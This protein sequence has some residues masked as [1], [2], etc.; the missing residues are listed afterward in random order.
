MLPLTPAAQAAV[1]R[2]RQRDRNQQGRAALEHLRRAQLHRRRVQA[3]RDT[4]H[5]DATSAARDPH[6][7]AAIDWI[8]RH[9][10]STTRQAATATGHPDP[11]KLSRAL[12]RLRAR[13]IVD[14]TITV[15]RTG[16]HATWH[17]VD[18]QDTP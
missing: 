13:G 16:R 6:N 14:S 1:E 7:Q 9:P 10:G 3:I 17:I 18:Q 11:A 5:G 15:D 4:I 2:I 8:R 12:W